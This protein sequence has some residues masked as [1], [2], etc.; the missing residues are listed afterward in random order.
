MNIRYSITI[1]KWVNILENT[2]MFKRQKKA[3]SNVV[4]IFQHT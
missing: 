1:M 3:E 4:K 2:K